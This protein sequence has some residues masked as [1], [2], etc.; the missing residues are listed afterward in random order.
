MFFTCKRRSIE[1]PI[2]V[3]FVY[4]NNNINFLQKSKLVASYF[5]KEVVNGL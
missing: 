1:L 4:S 2:V 5:T 3:C